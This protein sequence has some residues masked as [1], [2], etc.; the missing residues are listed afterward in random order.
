MALQDGHLV[1]DQI[2]ARELRVITESGE[3]FGVLSRL[4]A[5]EKA[6]QADLDLVLISK[7]D[8]TPPVAKI[9]DFGKFLYEKKKKQGEA[10]KHQKI[11]QIKEIKMR[12]NIGDQDYLTK[13]KKAIE[14]LSEGKKVKYTLQFRGREVIMMDEIGTKIFAKIL[15]DLEKAEVGQIAEEKDVKTKP[16]W[17]KI[18][19]IKAK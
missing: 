2:K 9:M 8:V 18:Y 1:N 17:T 15:T 4:E 12:P 5:L 14:F 11:I 19:S 10:K 3:N 16:F 7:E 13:L 6:K